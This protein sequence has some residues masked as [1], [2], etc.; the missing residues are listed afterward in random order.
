[1]YY[2]SWCTPL[3]YGGKFFPG[4]SGSCSLVVWCVV[5]LRSG[6]SSGLCFFSDTFYMHGIVFLVF[7]KNYVCL[8][9]VFLVRELSNVNF[10][11]LVEHVSGFFFL[12]SRTGEVLF[13]R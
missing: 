2:Q 5:L 6:S 11:G 8:R 12:I 7:V 10:R 1:M 4:L 13:Y 9:G 3:V